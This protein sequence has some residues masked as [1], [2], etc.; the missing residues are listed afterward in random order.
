MKTADL[1]ISIALCTYNGERFLQEQLDSLAAQTRL[2]DEV[3]VGDDGSTDRT[4]EILEQWAESVSFPVRIR[5]NEKNLGFAGNFEQTMLRCKG[6]ILFLCD[7]DDIWFPEK[8]ETM[9]RVFEEKPEVGV[10]YCG[11]SIVDGA[12]NP[13]NRE[14]AELGELELSTNYRELVH[15]FCHTH[16]NTSGCCTAVRASLLEKIFPLDPHY[17]HD[18]MI[19][20]FGL[21]YTQFHT[22]RQDL[23]HYRFHGSNAS[24]EGDWISFFNKK[25]TERKTFYKWISGTYFLMEPEIDYYQRKV[26]QVPDSPLRKK[27]LKMIAAAKRHYPNRHRVQQNFFVFF[28]LFFLEVFTGRYFQRFQ[29]FRSMAFDVW[30]GIK[31]GLNPIK[32]LKLAGSVFVKI[33][34]RIHGH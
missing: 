22:I 2:P 34:R 25:E 24:L 4:L 5:K 12:G 32:T 19:Y 8:L 30:A 1:T 31:N 10:V 6:E 18:S 21:F 3:V 33:A 29:P 23:M 20:M 26:L 27:V 13:I 9:I 17:C 7:Q 14:R 11:A 16:T 28:P 15:P